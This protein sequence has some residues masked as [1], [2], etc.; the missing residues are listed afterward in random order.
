M[1]ANRPRRRRVSLW[2]RFSGFWINN[3][4]QAF[5]SLGDLWRT[6]GA[7]MM[8]IAVIAVSL[9]LPGGFHVLLKNLSSVG[10]QWRSATEISL[11]LRQDLSDTAIQ[12]F[13]KRV[14]LYPEV[15][16]V[17]FISAEQGLKEFKEHSGFADALDHLDHNPLPAVL[18]VTPALRFSSPDGAR[19]LL[20]KLRGEREVEQG[21]LDLEWLQRLQA[22]VGLIRQI[23]TLVAG[24]LLASVLLIVGNTIRLNILSRRS[25]IE[26]MKL[27]G[28][29]D[30][31]IQR[32]FLYTGFWY[33]FIGGWLAW[34]LIDLMVLWVESSVNRLA[35][36]YNSPF[37]LE[38]IA[39]PEFGMLMVLSTGLGL[40]AS[41]TSVKRHIREIEPA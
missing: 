18:V 19:Q 39:L 33:G 12:T 28:A 40:L 21:K 26:V 36:L 13:V 29:T 16:A 5:N 41:Y 11:F 20:D 14:S 1:A 38:G 6:P 25:E 10:D 17:E 4:R 2:R 8:T 3:L 34:M 32:P 9:A 30:G 31:F 7:S 23:V 24:L 15:A 27:V 35:D 22:L 37:R